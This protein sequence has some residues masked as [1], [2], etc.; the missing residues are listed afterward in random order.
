MIQWTT[1]RLYRSKSFVERKSSGLL[2]IGISKRNWSKL[3]PEKGQQTLTLIGGEC[4]PSPPADAQATLMS[5]TA[6]LFEISHSHLQ[7]Y[8][9]LFLPDCR[10]NASKC[11]VTFDRFLKARVRQA[12]ISG[13]MNMISRPT[14]RRSHS[15]RQVQA[16]FF[17][18]QVV[19][20]EGMS[21]VGM[22]CSYS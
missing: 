13:T 4:A 20:S 11:D 10:E 6:I 5:L 19:M 3:T 12:S 15:S 1:V 21:R 7:K 9:E 16:C 2:C 8:P 17:M 18:E 14:I 22:M